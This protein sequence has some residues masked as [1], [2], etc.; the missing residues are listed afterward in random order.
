MKCYPPKTYPGQI[1]ERGTL[2]IRKKHSHINQGKL[3]RLFLLAFII[4]FSIFAHKV[5][6]DTLSVDIKSQPDTLAKI[7]KEL[8]EKRKSMEKLNQKERSTFEELL[9]LEERLDSTQRL[10]RDLVLK[11]KEAEKELEIEDLSLAETDSSLSY[12][13]ELSLK[14]LREIYEHKRFHP[15][16]I[17]FEASSPVEMVNRLKLTQRILKEDQD[18]LRKTKNLK[19]ELEEKKQ[20]LVKTKTELS[21][22]RQ[23]RA[24]EEIKYKKELLEKEK[25]LKKIKSEKKLYAQAVEELKK[26]ASELENIL[27]QIHHSTPSETQT[28]EEGWF[29]ISKGKLPWPIPGKVI[30]Y[31]GEQRSPQFHTKTKNSG[32]EIEAEPGKEVIAVAEGKVI[33]SSQLRGYG[34]I[35]ILEHD[36]GYY[37]LYARLS[38]ILV[39]RGEDVDRLQKIGVVGESGF[40]FTPCLHFE[41]R[42]GKQPQDPL[43]WLR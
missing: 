31:F 8:D 33:Y 4:W 19:A 18:L 26:N 24:K 36:G 38:E 12:Y 6:S 3:L 9:D 10:K 21:V 39:S 11:E 7:K 20:S 30:A 40:F 43:T 23:R 29:E 14:R 15:Y 28:K 25:L 34:N 37:T 32:I 17:I 2:R 42:K 35:V 16:A 27:A 1:V 22:L 41:I 13:R 5:F